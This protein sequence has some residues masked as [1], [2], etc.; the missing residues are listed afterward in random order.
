MVKVYERGTGFAAFPE[1]PGQRGTPPTP[2][3]PSSEV[4]QQADKPPKGVSW[5]SF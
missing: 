1:A 4:T 2:A 3:E 5:V